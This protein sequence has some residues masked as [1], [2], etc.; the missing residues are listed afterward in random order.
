M[1]GPDT[2]A[3]DQPPPFIHIRLATHGRSIQL[4]QTEKNSVRNSQ[5]PSA[6][7]NEPWKRKNDA[8]SS[9]IA[10]ATV[11]SLIRGHASASFGI[12]GALPCLVCV[13]MAASPA[14]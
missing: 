10:V 4:G 12:G 3:Q 13:I 6:F 5:S 14:C 1:Q 7:S 11:R 2:D 9:L 8:L